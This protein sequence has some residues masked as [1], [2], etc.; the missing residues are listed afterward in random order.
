MKLYL[1]IGHG[2]EPNGVLDNGAHND[3]DGTDEHDLN[4]RV[5]VVAD[6]AL[7][8]CG[9]QHF[10]EQNS[11]ASH[12]V[13][14]RGSVIAVNAGRFDVALEVH[15]D[16]ADAP[17]GGFGIYLHE[18]GQRLA[19]M[20]RNHWGEMGL[21]Q[22]A[23]YADVRGLWFLQGS[24]CPAVIWEC[25]RTAAHDDGE[26]TRMGEAIAAGVCDYVGVPYRRDD[27][28]TPGDAM[29]RFPNAVAACYAPGGGVWVLGSDGGVGAYGGAP[30]HG[31]YPA[32]PPEARRGERRFLTII[33]NGRDGYDLLA[34][35]GASYSF[36]TG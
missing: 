21:P 14:Y 16:S 17:R 3:A 8:R 11:G 15:F 12:D 23:N 30:F 18:D 32:L 22:R 2:I 35:D 29:A 9:V 10:T 7:T 28:T 1:G 13:D 19:Q 5:C 4:T 20:I 27:P 36:P 31:S 6:A 24:N 33:P 34:D 25:D 26:I